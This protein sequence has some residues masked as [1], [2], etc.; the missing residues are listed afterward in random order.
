MAMADRPEGGDNAAGANRQRVQVRK[1]GNNIKI[2][3]ND[4]GADVFFGQAD[5]TDAGS[6]WT[7]LGNAGNRVVFTPAS[8]SNYPNAYTLTNV[9]HNQKVDVL[10]KRGGKLTLWNGQGFYD[11]VFMT[12]EALNSGELPKFKARKAIWDLYQELFRVNAVNTYASALATANAVYVNANATT[13]QLRAAFRALFLAVAESIENPVDVSYLFT[14]PDIS[15][16]KT[17][18]GWSYTDF[19][20][21][22][23]ECEKY[24][25][26]FSSSQSVSD[27]PNGLYEVVF[28]G[29]YRQDDGKNQAAPQLVVTSGGSPWTAN[30]PN[31][32]DLGGKWNI[33][34]DP[35]GDWV[36]SNTGKKPKWMWSASDAQA[37]E[38]ASA[39]IESVKVKDHTLNVEFKVTGGNQWFNFQRV[40]ITYKGSINSGLYKTLQ[41]KIAEANDYVTANTGVIPASF[42]TPITEALSAASLLTANSDDN[43]L[44]SATDA[45]TAALNTAKAAPTIANLNVLQA[46]VNLASNEGANAAAIAAAEAFLANPTTTDALKAQLDAVRTARKIK[47]LGGASD[48]YTGSAPV[49]DTEYYF[50]NLGTGMW[51]S[52]GSDWNTH[53]AV[54]QAGWIYKLNDATDGFTISCSMGWFNGTP[55]VDTNDKKVYTFQAVSG[56]TNV[57]NILQGSDL[58]GYNPNGKTDGKKYWNSVSNVAGADATDLN[59]QWKLVTKAERDALLEQATEQNPVDATYLIDNPSLLRKPGYE[60]WT[61]ECDGGNGGARVSTVNDGNGDRA[62]DF[63]YEYYEPNSFSFSQQLSALRPGKYK[64]SVQA[65]Y[66]HGNGDT[67]AAAVNN[68]DE[69]VQ[70]AYLFANGEQTLLPNVASVRDLVPGIGDLRATNAGE[71]PNMPQSAIEYFE[72]GA[73]KTTVQVKVGTDGQLNIGVKKDSRI[74][75]GD[76]VVFDNFRLAYLGPVEETIDVAITDAGYATLV[77]PFD[78]TMPAGVTASTAEVNGQSIELTAISGAVP[79]HTPVILSAD[80]AKSFQ[81][82][83]YPTN[84]PAELKAGALV[85]TYEDIQAPD[86]SYVLQSQNGKV[87]FYQVEQATATPWVRANRA[88]LNAPANPVKAFFFEDAVDG[89]RTMDNGQWTMDNAE[90]F[91]V[92]GQRMNKL[93]RGVNIVNGKKVLVK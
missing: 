74:L 15:G 62:A 47:A 36:T 50:F 4:R 41:A 77:A 45:I 35:S 9:Q 72:V 37:H 3:W 11:W 17:A 71:F 70:L 58:L 56:K 51:L 89:I 25:A 86:G 31:M 91:N 76:W 67:Q 7:D 27:A 34:G 18:S 49:V 87:G 8:S 19:A 53:A 54:D 20:I 80:A 23:G 32:E 26:T 13:D 10:W 29:I 66:R 85:G 43:D 22:A 78:A 57:Y 48:I 38:D 2:H 88:Y 69:L 65:F 52:A 33:G 55:Y 64:V 61:K 39:I 81:I 83:G 60:M 59:Y 12:D 79:A 6:M 40:F 44:T 93:Q 68:G 30:F 42:I 21:S 84:A 28:T 75:G 82:S 46:T 1:D 73:Y 14:H 16:D 90:I 92:A 5:N 63:A 24:H